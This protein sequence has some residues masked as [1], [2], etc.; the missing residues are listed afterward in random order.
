[1]ILKAS[2]IITVTVP[3]ALPTCI[4]VGISVALNRFEFVLILCDF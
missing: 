2:E 4:Q 1:V 3:P